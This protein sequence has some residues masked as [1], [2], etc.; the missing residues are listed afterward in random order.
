VH[1]IKLRVRICLTK[2]VETWALP[3][4]GSF[5]RKRF[6][7]DTNITTRKNFKVPKSRV[8]NVV[9]FLYLLKSFFL[10]FYSEDEIGRLVEQC[11]AMSRKPIQVDIG[12]QPPFPTGSKMF[13]DNF[14]NLLFLA[15]FNLQGHFEGLD[16]FFSGSRF[17]M[18]VEG[19]D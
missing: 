1:K 12:G 10:R 11:R 4:L 14:V 17:S 9:C 6:Q 8:K 2:Y 7:Y 19:F 3:R 18:I 16:D 13:S 15:V 5:K